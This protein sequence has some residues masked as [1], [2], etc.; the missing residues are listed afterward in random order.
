MITTD[1]HLHSDHSGDCTT[2]T[3]VMITKGIELGLTTMCF[4]QHQDFDYPLT[5]IFELNTEAY[6]NEFLL[7]KEKYK[8][9]IKLLFG[10]ELGLQKQIA[11]KNEAYARSYDFDFII[12][13]S[14]VANQK[15]PYYP[16]FFEGR[17]E[18]EAFDEYFLANLENINSFQNFDVYG[19]LD[20][21]VRYA[22]NTNLNYS[23][24]NHA[25]LIDELL[26]SL[27]KKEKGI[28]VNTSGFH[29]GLN[30]THP[31]PEIIRRY[32]ELGGSIITIGSDAHL[33]DQIA[34]KFDYVSDLL[35]ECGFTYYTVFEKRKASFIKL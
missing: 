18:K 3:E 2:P 11:S 31:F 14:H 7:L 21:V 16:E 28:E 6:L 29:K 25:E 15:D 34:T 1:F 13:S 33:P 5:T 22:P 4:T 27:I 10:V 19:H 32:R 8:S 23:Y 35:K 24:Q 26:R 9:D 30:T 17:S 12:G 20:Y